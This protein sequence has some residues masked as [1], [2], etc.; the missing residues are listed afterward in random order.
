MAGSLPLF[1]LFENHHYHPTTAPR[2]QPRTQL[3]LNHT[4]TLHTTMPRNPNKDGYATQL[5]TM[6]LYHL[7][8]DGGKDAIIQSGRMQRGRYV[9]LVL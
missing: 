4:P 3:F 9:G 5:D 6:T 1:P 2:F 7:T 8:G